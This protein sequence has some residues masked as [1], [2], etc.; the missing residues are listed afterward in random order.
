MAGVRH[1]LAFV[2]MA[3]ALPLSGCASMSPPLTAPQVAE[4][5]V[6]IESELAVVPEPLT[7]P[8]AVDDAVARAVRFNLALRAKE[9][10]AAMA[11]AKVVAESGAMLPSVVAESEYY[12]RDRPLLTR[13]NMSDVY[14]TSSDAKN[15]TRDIALSWNILDFGLSYIRSKQGLDKALQQREEVRR[16]RARIIEE[17]RSLFWRAVVLDKLGPAQVR[18]KPEVDEAIRLSRL[19]AQDLMVDP[20]AQVTFQRDLL[21]LQR[22]L[23]QLDL[24]LAGSDGQ[25]KTSIGLPLGERVRLVANRS[26]VK[27]TKITTSVDDDLRVALN[28]RPEIRQH[29]YDMRITEDE[30]KATLLQLLPGVTLSKTSASDTNSFL[31]N[32]N[33]VSL[34]TKV[35]ANLMNLARLPADLASIESQ[36]RMHRENALATG[37]AIAMQLHVARA[38]IAVQQRSYRDAETYAKAQRELMQQVE[39]SVTIGKV[40]QQALAR[41]KLATLLADAR[42]IVAFA[43]LHAAYAAYAT[44][45]GDDLAADAP[46]AVSGFAD[47]NVAT[48]LTPGACNVVSP[49]SEQPCLED[50]PPKPVLASAPIE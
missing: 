19:A 29:M 24:S 47:W 28:Q 23:N 13:S 40:G 34:G 15:V 6:R 44:A 3:A 43:D 1:R 48:F 42:V 7:G 27:L 39:A 49:A 36:M 33:W 14:S 31:Y 46:L 11:E 50:T 25:L 17:T 9:L 21:N 22:D 41:E 10:E 35:A 5:S 2:A 45:R 26:Q 18:L 38:R 12:R 20:M 8:L 4:F 32:A 30:V 37:A 16:V